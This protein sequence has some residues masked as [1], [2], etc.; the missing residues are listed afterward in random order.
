MVKDAIKIRGFV[1]YMLTKAID[2]L[3]D[4]SMNSLQQYLHHTIN[5]LETVNNVL[6]A[7]STKIALKLIKEDANNEWTPHDENGNEIKER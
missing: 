7:E 4:S 5:D 3:S 6:N 2:D 1:D